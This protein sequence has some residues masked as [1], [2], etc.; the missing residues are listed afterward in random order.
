MSELIR[1]RTTTRVVVRSVVKCLGPVLGSIRYTIFGKRIMLYNECINL[2]KN[3]EN[4]KNLAYYLKV[5][6]RYRHELI[7]EFNG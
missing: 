4:W 7:L 2:L 1:A 5:A 6:G 3:P